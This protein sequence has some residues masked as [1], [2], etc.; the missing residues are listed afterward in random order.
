MTRFLLDTNVI[1]ESARPAPDPKVIAFLE[2]AGDACLSAVSLF[3]ICRGIERLAAGR[4]RSFLEAWFEELQT[5]AFEILSL[6]KETALIAARLEVKLGR[7]GN[8]IEVRDLFIAASA[9]EHGL[10]LVTRNEAHF[11]GLGLKVVNPF[12]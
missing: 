9:S 7:T 6:A 2:A 10:T 11:E 1:S 8:S 12:S 3:E 4:R 5:G